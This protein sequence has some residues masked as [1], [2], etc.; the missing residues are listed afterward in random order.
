MRD[1]MIAASIR[2]ALSR[3]F[4]PIAMPP[5]RYGRGFF[6]LLTL[7][8]ATT[9]ITYWLLVWYWHVRWF[10]GEDRL[11]EWITVANFTLAAVFAGLSWRTLR[12]AGHRRIALLQALLAAVFLLIVLEEISWGQRIFGFETP[13]AIAEVNFQGETTLHNLDGFDR[14]SNTVTALAAWLAVIGGLIGLTLHRRRLVTSANMLLPSLIFVPPLALIIA[15]NTG[16][17]ALRDLAESFGPRPIGD[18]APELLTS[19][20]AAVYCGMV[21]AKARALRKLRSSE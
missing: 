13:D 20:C 12:H 19:V 7:M 16:G 2:R 15:W 17:S 3:Y 1:L 4:E 9:V 10:A 6:A 5:D 11:V 21:L 8:L 18:E 14:V